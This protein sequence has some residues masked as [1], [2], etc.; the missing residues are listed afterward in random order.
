[1][2]V[3]DVITMLEAERDKL[4]AAIKVLRGRGTTSSPVKLEKEPKAGRKRKISAAARAKMA[5][6]ARERW[7]KKKAAPRKAAK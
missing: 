6:A 3:D 7:A 5:Q 4:D 2:P 1:M